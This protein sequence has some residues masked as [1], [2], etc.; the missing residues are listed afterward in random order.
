MG[1]DITYYRNLR[2]LDCV[3]DAH[4][5]PIDP[6]TR[7]PMEAHQ[8]YANHDFQKQA[9]GIE[10]MYD[11]E[12]AGGFCAGSYG[13]Y[14]NWREDLAKLAGYPALECERHGVAGRHDAGAWEAD[15]GLFHELIHFSDCEGT[16]GPVTSAKLAK[17]FADFQDRADAF[18]DDYWRDKYAEWR[19]A[20]ETAAKENGAV[21]FH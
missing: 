6:V 5:E 10:G 1:L 21:S 19:K 9:D 20:F 13:G 16:I 15:G 17:D 7:A 2:K 14:N 11:A 18:G 12:K 3:F 8:F 4:G